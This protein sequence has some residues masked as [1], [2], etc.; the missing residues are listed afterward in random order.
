MLKIVIYGNDARFK[1]LAEFFKDKYQVIYCNEL[2]QSSHVKDCDILVLP[3][4][5]NMENTDAENLFGTLK[6][7]TLVLGGK[8]SEKLKS[9]ANQYNIELYDY[10]TDEFETLNAIPSAEGAIEVAMNQTDFTLCG[11][12]VFVLGFG[13]I[14]KIL[15][16][17]LSGIGAKVT[18]CARRKESLALAKG[19]GFKTV[20]L[21]SLGSHISR[22]DIIFNTI[23][24]LILDRT[25]LKNIK[26]EGLVIDL[27]SKP[28]GV[29]FDCAKELGIKT[30]HALGLPA[31]TSPETSSEILCN[32]I[33]SFIEERRTN[34][35]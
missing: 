35:T 13:R 5:C 8:V 28:G 18:V 31:K 34:G 9:V 24:S 19:L 12:M 10:Y 23:P 3:L 17:M 1:T 22:A 25:V 11:S 26:K 21:Q 32:S 4:P 14:G 6:P 7:D 30:I 29:D 33:C 15:A 20:P 16:K 27:A 2:P